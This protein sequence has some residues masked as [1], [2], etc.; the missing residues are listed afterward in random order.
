MLSAPASHQLEH[1]DVFLVQKMCTRNHLLHQKYIP[2]FQLVRHL[3]G[4]IFDIG[5]L[6]AQLALLC[7][8][9]KQMSHAG[10]FMYVAEA[11]SAT[12]RGPP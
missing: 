7:T 11:Y 6:L 10:C 5:K 3:Q 9:F 1:G 12:W 8:T 2:M 4:C